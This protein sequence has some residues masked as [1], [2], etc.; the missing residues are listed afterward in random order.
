MRSINLVLKKMISTDKVQ[1]FFTSIWKI[2]H[3]SFLFPRTILINRATTKMTILYSQNVQ[4]RGG[5]T[6]KI[7]VFTDDIIPAEEPTTV[8][9]LVLKSSL[10][11]S[12]TALVHWIAVWPS[13]VESSIKYWS[14]TQGLIFCIH[15]SWIFRQVM[16]N[17]SCLFLL[18]RDCVVSTYVLISAF[19]MRQASSLEQ[20]SLST[21]FLLLLLYHT[22]LFTL[23]FFLI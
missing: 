17:I 15:L 21:I 6:I 8:D 16:R 23:I 2:I 3:A 19:Q 5:S 14:P 11:G 12:C 22:I 9:S 10:D 7:S 20:T 18:F 4:D 13:A 1:T